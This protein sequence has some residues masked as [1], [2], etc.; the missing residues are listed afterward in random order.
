[1]E[2]PQLNILN[3]ANNNFSGEI[4]SSIGSLS[5]LEALALHSNSLYGKLPPSWNNCSMLIFLDLSTNGLW[6]EIPA[7]IGESLSSLIFLSLHSNEFS[8]SIPLHPCQLAKIQIFDLSVNNISGTMPKCLNNFT[9]MV[10]EGESEHM[11]ENSY[12]VS[13][14]SGTVGF[15]TTTRTRPW[16][17]GK[18]VSTSMEGI[19]GCWGLLILQATN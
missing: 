16:L 14:T 12:A 2:W 10:K 6:R 17:N 7:W 4:P 15:G 11:I 19:L 1:M 3:L 18:E 13:M 5:W 8:G 9:S